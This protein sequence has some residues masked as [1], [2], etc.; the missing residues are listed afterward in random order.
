MID[1]PGVMGLSFGSVW[2]GNTLPPPELL[3]MA[4]SDPEDA[5]PAFFCR[6]MNDENERRATPTL[7][8]PPPSEVERDTLP[9]GPD[10]IEATRVLATMLPGKPPPSLE[11]SY[12][13]KAIRVVAE[14]GSDL[15][16]D[17]EERR[18]Q[19]QAVLDAIRRSDENQSRNYELLR[20]EIK[21]LKDSDRD[22]DRRLAEGDE[23]FAQIENSIE[24]LKDELLAAMKSATED[25]A[26]R[27]GA[28]EG[29]LDKLRANAPRAPE[30]T[31]AAKPA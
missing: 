22:Q 6:P 3:A 24:S 16:I 2:T 28:L 19:H 9:P 13:D 8:S 31:T 5:N 20:I 10:D 23:R 21:H 27:I 25:A 7:E 30:T 29:E 18:K 26:R 12:L 1:S 17:R 4:L 14:A 11:G 15:R